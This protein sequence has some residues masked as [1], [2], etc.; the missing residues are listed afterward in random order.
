MPESRA[1]ERESRQLLHAKRQHVYRIPFQVTGKTFVFSTFGLV[2][3][4]L[5]DWS[6]VVPGIWVG[7]LPGIDRVR[8]FGP[9]F[10]CQGGADS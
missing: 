9:Q 2:R 3:E 7:G 4:N 6:P 8:G 5:W 10:D 1:F